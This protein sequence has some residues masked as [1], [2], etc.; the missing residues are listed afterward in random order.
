MSGL[1]ANIIGICG[2]VIFIFAFM[3]ANVATVINKLWF[4]IANLVGAIFLLASLFVH[5]NLAAVILESAWA[6]IAIVGIFKALSVQVKLNH[7]D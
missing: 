7:E 1:M 5:F 3:Y 6:I 4:N 2:S